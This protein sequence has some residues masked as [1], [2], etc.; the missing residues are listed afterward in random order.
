MHA[1]MLECNGLGIIAPQ[2]Y[3]SKRVIIVASSANPYYPDALEMDLVVMVN[4]E[5]IE[6]SQATCLGEEGDLSVPNE[7]GGVERA[8]AVKVRYYTLQGEV[9]V[10]VFLHVLFS[11]KLL[12]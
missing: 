2:V 9:V 7:R 12:I 3:I 10:R 6:F 8:Q 5:I 4:P 11:M 1:T